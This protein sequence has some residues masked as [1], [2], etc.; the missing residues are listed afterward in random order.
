[1]KE[2]IKSP[3][4]IVKIGRTLASDL[5][6]FRVEEKAVA[7][8]SVNYSEIALVE[9]LIFQRLSKKQYD[10]IVNYMYKL[11]WDINLEDIIVSV[12]QARE[13]DNFSN[14][15]D[16]S[17]AP[18]TRGEIAALEAKLAQHTGKHQRILGQLSEVIVEAY[19]KK[20]GYEIDS[21][22]DE[23]DKNKIDVIA[24]K[25]NE[26]LFGQIK[27]GDI[28]YKEIYKCVESVKSYKYKI[29]G[30]LI[31][32]FFARNFPEDIEFK[33]ST[34]EMDSEF[35]ILFVRSSEIAKAL[36]QYRHALA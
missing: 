24:R 23:D 13:I 26:I 34:I 30:N 20:L 27:T 11:I 14:P 33:R 8:L 21:T 25:G 35:R 3:L 18:P 10:I 31:C 9:M 32:A 7:R 16:W 4:S 28:N 19:L 22:T 6:L 1:M 29:G 12:Y 36:R 2:N 17:E 5:Y 15:Y